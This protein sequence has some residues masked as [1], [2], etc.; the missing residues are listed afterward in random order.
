M[1]GLSWRTRACAAATATGIAMC[2]GVAAAQAQT[3]PEK[4]GDGAPTG[5]MG[6]QLF[7]Y[8]GFINNGGGL[9]TSPPPLAIAPAPDG[10]SCA[11]ATS[12]DCRWSRL[13]AL[14]SFLAG[15]GLSTVEL[16]G[17]SNF[18]ANSDTAGL[19]RYRALLD[20]YNLSCGGWHGSMSEAAWAD[21]VA[22]AKILG[23]DSIG[24]GGFPSPGIGS[25]DNVLRTVEALNRLGKA[26]IEGGVGP[27]Y[28]H[29][30]QQEFRNRYVDNGVRKTAWQIV[31]ERMDQ[32]YAFAEVDAGWS[33][34]AYDD[35]TGTVTAGLID[36]FPN[37]VKML[38]I[39][40]MNRTVPLDPPAGPGKPSDPLAGGQ[41]GEPACQNS[42]P[43][44]WG[45]GEIDWRP[46]LNAAANRVEWYHQEHDGGTLTH[47]DVSFTN[48]KGRNTQVKG[49][50]F[51]RTTTFPSVAAGTPAA[52]NV[53]QVKLENAGDAALTITGVAL[54]TG[55]NART[56][57]APGDFSIVSNSC[58][59]APIPAHIPPS[60][61]NPGGVRSS[62]VVN[63][64][65]KPTV[66]N[67]TSVTR[68]LVTSN[69]DS[70]TEQIYLVGRSTADSL[71]TVGGSVDSA[72]SL[73]L[74]GAASFGAFL[75]A[76]AR[77]YDTATSATV[78]AT[79]GDA[80]LSV[81]DAS[82]TATGH[83]VN[84]TFA[85]PAALQ[86]RAANGAQNNPAFQSLS[87]D[88]TPVTLLTYSGPTAGADPVTIGFRQSIG[89]TD[90]LRAG[91][92]SKTLTFTV[93][94]TTP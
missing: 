8:G 9:G 41:P 15:K 58:V 34:D 43:T 81:F 72:L 87:D 29:N 78:V 17:H 14:F 44:A 89:A 37:A 2:F 28:F 57:E 94:S 76:T 79:T 65:F 5:Q 10:S 62:C 50:V 23:C 12:A 35:V 90:V 19:T 83:L 3:F 67:K 47:A 11:T 39:K 26:S 61:S 80:A 84:G 54:A 4:T 77:N 36:Q 70:A 1:K 20:K 74:G 60:A 27:V 93:S 49:A 16:F 71:G 56:D 25:Y 73:T 38:H 64:G 22:A 52:S 46:I 30:H 24:S 86:V 92:Y 42:Q 55:G 75:P 33:S 88:G 48:L 59:G 6:A 18:P 7:N 63:V 31:M 68:L 85:L 66:S 21:R 91:N 53:V 32:R 45:T 51:G 13:E 69:A 40:D 82:T